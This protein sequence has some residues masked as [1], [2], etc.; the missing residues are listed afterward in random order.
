MRLAKALLDS[1]EW[2]VVEEFLEFCSD[3]WDSDE[4]DHWMEQVAV[5]EMPL[6]EFNLWY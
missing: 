5:R 1:G 3:F 6:F 4:L 2:E